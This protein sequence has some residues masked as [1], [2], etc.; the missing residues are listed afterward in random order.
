MKLETTL[1]D[2]A[3]QKLV[4]M[5][6]AMAEKDADTAV[7]RWYELNALVEIGQLQDSGLSDPGIESLQE[8]ELAS[9][10]T[11]HEIRSMRWQRISE[12]TDW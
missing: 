7:A 5:R 6:S 9:T 4:A 3:K 10:V 12:G 8:I 1:I 2:S 11:I